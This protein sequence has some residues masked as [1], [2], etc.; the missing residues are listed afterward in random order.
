M[1]VA[2]SA[3]V[4]VTA[5]G[6]TVAQGDEP[7]VQALPPA[8]VQ[9]A[10]RASDQDVLKDAEARLS[11]SDVVA[12][13]KV[14]DDI[15]VVARTKNAKGQART[16]FARM[17]YDEGLGEWYIAESWDRPN[18]GGGFTWA[19]LALEDGHKIVVWDEK[20]ENAAV[21]IDGEAVKDA[22]RGGAVIFDEELGMDEVSVR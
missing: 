8:A 7:E 2:A 4:V 3:A 17:T 21:V 9:K 11:E 5:S 13:H 16:V 12:G 15:V 6:V 10:F 20:P 19:Q 1:F 18:A 22:R 14:G